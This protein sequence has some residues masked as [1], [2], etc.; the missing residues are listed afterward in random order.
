MEWINAIV[1][2]VAA[3]LFAVVLKV[4]ARAACPQPKKLKPADD[5]RLGRL[6]L[7]ATAKYKPKLTGWDAV[8]DSFNRIDAQIREQERELERLRK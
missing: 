1:P 7:P 6:G 4:K 3:L 2:A 8:M 5:E